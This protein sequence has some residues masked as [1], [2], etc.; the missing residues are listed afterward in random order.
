MRIGF[1]GTPAFAAT[2]LKTLL[3]SSHEVVS[4]F[5]QP[6]RVA[7]RG[8]KLRTSEVQQ[9]CEKY[10]IDTFTPTRLRGQSDLFQSFEALVVAAYGLILPQSILDTPRLGCFNV[11]A[12]LL[13]RWRGAA[14][15]EHAIMNGD[16]ETGISIMRM[17][18]ALDAGPIYRQVALPLFEGDT[19]E[20][21]TRKLADIGANAMLTTL[22]YAE[23]GTLKEPCPQQESLATYAPSLSKDAAQINWNNKALTIERQV[24][25]FQGRGSAYAT[26]SEKNNSVRLRILEASVEHGVGKPGTLIATQNGIAIACGKDLLLVR[27]VQLNLGKGRPMSIQDAMNGYPNLLQVGSQLNTLHERDHD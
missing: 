16:S 21:V 22:D 20:I 10:Q 15:I 27:R 25:A 14:P 5:T 3:A 1:A 4:V 18:R 6:A 17:V 12:S 2:I 24:R 19:T 13:P 7:G 11:H 9:V 26:W 23:S 8:R